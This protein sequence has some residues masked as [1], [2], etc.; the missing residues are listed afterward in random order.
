MQRV[1]LDQLH[2]LILWSGIILLLTGLVMVTSASLHVAASQTGNAFYFSQHQAVYLLLGLVAAALVY[3]L[4]PLAWLKTL[5]FPALALAFGTLVVVLIPGI[6]VEVNGSR[7]WINLGLFT[8]QASE[9]VKLCFVVY[10]AG[11]IETRRSALQRDWQSF[12]GPIAVLGLLAGLLLAEPDF[13]AVVVLGIC[14]LGMLMMAGVPTKYFSVLVI[15]ALLLGGLI[16]VAEPYRVARL[17]SFLDPWSDQYGAGYQLTQSLIAFGRGHWFGAGLG[18]GVQKLF[19]L[20]EAHTD[21]VF[22]VLAEELG[23]VGVSCVLAVFACLGYSI[24]RLGWQLQQHGSMHSAQL[25]YGIAMILCAQ[26]FINM[27]VTMG[28]LP[29]KGLTLPLV[30]YGGS[31]LIISMV[32]LALVLRAAA[33]HDSRRERAPQ[34]G[35]IE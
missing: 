13:G 25:V 27:G 10:L 7:R 6:G 16:A 8:V 20:P 22:A 30:S 35:R 26:V 21:F 12:F 34:T 11:Y 4:V 14:A 28:I 31:S 29:T 9:I 2:P 17:M 1:R 3:F 32:M 33:E 18:Q 24:L 15:G 5:R 23:L 19:Y